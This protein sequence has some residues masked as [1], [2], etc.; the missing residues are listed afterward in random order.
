VYFNDRFSAEGDADGWRYA[1]TK[2]RDDGAAQVAKKK[3]AEKLK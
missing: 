1:K 2:E 3:T